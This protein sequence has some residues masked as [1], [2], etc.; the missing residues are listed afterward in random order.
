M[1]NVV[2]GL[3]VGLDASTSCCQRGER[4][5]GS[6]ANVRLPW[7][8]VD[9]QLL[10]ALGEGRCCEPIA[11]KVV[12]AFSI[13]SVSCSWRAPIVVTALAVSTRKFV[14]TGWS[15]T[16]SAKKWSV[17]AERGREVFGRI[18][19]SARLAPDVLFGQA[20][21]ELLQALA[22][23]RVERVEQLVEVGDFVASRAPAASR[24]RRSAGALLGPGDS[25]M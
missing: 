2:S 7:R 21:D 24:R 17:A 10:Q 14:N 3:L 5:T 8:R 13:R 15:R 12:L 4:R 23:L 18:R 11:W 20:L 9:G 6:S 25:A 19:R 1:K 16:S 22:R